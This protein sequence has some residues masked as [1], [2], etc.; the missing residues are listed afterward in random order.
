MQE[1]R[2]RV[3]G[4]DIVGIVE[5][6]TTS[7]ISDAEL[8]IDGYNM[9]RLD[10]NG[11]K[12]GGLVMYINDRI[13]SSLCTEM[14]SGE[15]AESI[16]CNITIDTGKVLIGMCYRCPDSQREN[17]ESL[18]RLFDAAVIQKGVAHVMIF[19]DFNYPEID[20]ERDNVIWQELMHP[21]PNFST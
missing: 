1:L 16:W 14:M 2:K 21:Q 5:T 20:Y 6:W 18:L 10:R 7:K 9:Y 19:G 4:C 3:E 15:F 17:D 8:T 13:R 11:N 12:G